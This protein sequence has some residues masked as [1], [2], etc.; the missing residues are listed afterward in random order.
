MRDKTPYDPVR[1]FTPIILATRAPNV[2]VVHPSVA[3]TSVAELIALAKAK[4]NTLNYASG[5]TGASNHLAGELFNAMAGVKITRV[6]Y[7]GIGPAINDLLGGHVQM[8]F[9]T[10]GSA[11]AHVKSGKLRALGVT[12][13]QPSALFPGVPPIAASGLR[14]YEAV[15]VAAMF[16]PAR[17]PAVLIGKLNREVQALLHSPSTKD[18]FFAIGVETVGGSAAELAQYVK[19]DME[20]MGKV[21]KDAGIREE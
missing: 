3:A 4:P 15:A 21:I 11:V 20:R 16:A 9:A 18:K 12:S 10:A 19:A 1:D 5:A 8:S 14:G 7:Q 2:L 6:P 17:T 13:M